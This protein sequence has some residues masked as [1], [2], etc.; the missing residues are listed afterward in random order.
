MTFDHDLFKELG[1]FVISKVKIGNGKYI[2]V[3][4]KCTIAIK[5]I[6]STKLIKHVLFVTNINPNLLS[7]S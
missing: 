7:V 5:C 6:S 2:A 3:K 1:T 4:G